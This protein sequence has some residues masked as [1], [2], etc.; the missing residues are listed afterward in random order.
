MEI[1][2]D[3]EQQVEALKRFW[4]EYGKAIFG[5][6][7]IGVA[8]LYGWRFYQAEQRASAE[9][10]S[11]SY[12]QLVQKQASEDDFLAEA[13]TFISEQG[14]NNYAVFA[15]LLA[16]KDAVTAENFAEAIKQLSW[17]QQNSKDASVKAIAQLRLARVQRQTGD[18]T[19][20]L[21]TL[22]QA[23]P[24]SFVGQ[25]AELK[26]DVLQATGDLVAAKA[27]YQ[28]AF[29]NAGQNTQLLQIKLDELAHITAAN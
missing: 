19:G 21:A 11:N 7:I 3:E 12:A 9:A 4:N 5:G 15:A 28:V 16:A 23:V 18:Y 8:A 26:G 27:A 17:V 1:Y 29:S 24:S 14:N 13:Q 22:E 6:V 25:Q 10:L 20:A 2:T